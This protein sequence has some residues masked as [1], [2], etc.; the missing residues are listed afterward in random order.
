MRD[1][2]DLVH[3]CNLRGG[4]S[5]IYSNHIYNN[6]CPVLILWRQDQGGNADVGY[7]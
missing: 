1:G 7:F 5:F 4:G 6:I 2:E 3:I